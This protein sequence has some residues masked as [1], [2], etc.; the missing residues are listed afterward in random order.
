MVG[1][2]VGTKAKSSRNVGLRA[3]MDALPM[4]E[5]GQP[6]HRSTI[7]GAFHGCGHDGHTTMLLGCAEYLS[8]HRSS[9]AGTVN[10]FFQP[11]EESDG[12]AKVMIDEGL[13]DKFPCEEVYAMHN[14]PGLKQGVVDVQSGECFFL[15]LCCSGTLRRAFLL[16]F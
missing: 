12:G 5:E 13:F 6:L 4:Q 14:W 1:T 15:F 3:D 7:P 16:Y 9:F 8:T 2:I 11:A 10:V